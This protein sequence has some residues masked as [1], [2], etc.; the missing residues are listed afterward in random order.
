[1]VVTRISVPGA[2]ALRLSQL[3]FTVRDRANAGCT[4]TI[5]ALSGTHIS[6]VQ[7]DA[8]AAETRSALRMD[9]GHRF[10]VFS[11]LKSAVQTKNVFDL[12]PTLKCD[13]SNGNGS[14]QTA[15]RQLFF[16]LV[17]PLS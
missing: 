17:I 4:A 9:L 12:F 5:K 7:I 14:V 13:I 1:M 8:N 16:G 15:Q 2:T 3:A 6:G 11:F 10:I